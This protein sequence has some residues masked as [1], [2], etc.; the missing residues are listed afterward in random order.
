[1]SGLKPNTVKEAQHLIQVT[2]GR[3]S[4]GWMFLV[5]CY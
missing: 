2:D 3:V 4:P 1:M 5:M